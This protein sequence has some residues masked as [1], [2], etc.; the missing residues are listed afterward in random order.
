M[1]ALSAA[2]TNAR[3]ADAPRDTAFTDRWFA[4]DSPWN[5][6]IP[7]DVVDL[8]GSRGFIDA[9]IASGATININREIWTPIVLYADGSVPACD[10]TWDRWRLADVPLHSSLASGA[11]FFASRKDTDASFCIYSTS[12]KGFYNL[13]NSQ[14]KNINGRR[15]LKVGAAALFPSD[16]VGW[17]NNAAGPWSGRASGASYCG[18]LVR[19]SEF[20]SGKI[21]HALAM[22]WP[23]R[24]VRNG[25]MPGAFVF[26]ARTSDG[27]GRSAVNSVPMGA[28][29]QLDPQLTDT[30]LTDL[31]I[32]P[33]DLPIAHAMQ[34]YGSY[35]VDSSSAMAIYAESTFN[36]P[37]S[38]TSKSRRGF[39]LEILQH[40]RFVGPPTEGRLDD[41]ST[42]G[43]PSL[44][45]NA[46]EPARPCSLDPQN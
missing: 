4:S 35:V 1:A 19:Q 27:T 2:V 6:P 20:G 41:R 37:Q 25:R 36:N 24:L 30:E 26:P 43:Q 39:P 17:W 29:L 8:P 42:V 18:G 3:A 9:F 22:G 14:I 34:R 33:N 11:E 10:M 12:K 40:A 28:R 16:G 21:D 31:G 38:A 45:A 15:E 13:F 32:D 23:S 7:E 5:A 46:T 44:S